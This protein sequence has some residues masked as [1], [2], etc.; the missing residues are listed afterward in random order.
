MWKACLRIF[1]EQIY[2]CFLWICF[3]HLTWKL[4][5]QGEAEDCKNATAWSV[6]SGYAT[7]NST[8]QHN[9]PSENGKKTETVASYRLF[10]IDLMKPST[11]TTREEEFVQ[12]QNGTGGLTEE[13]GHS[14][15]SAAD[16][17]QKSDLSKVSQEN[18]ENLASPKDMQS[19]QGS[20]TRTRTKVFYK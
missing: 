14:L 2:S 6:F 19:K 16:S 10:G 20:S 4:E 5:L 11:S 9:D 13:H 1:M 12:E 7:P 3:R 8:T 15:D 18:K 17:E